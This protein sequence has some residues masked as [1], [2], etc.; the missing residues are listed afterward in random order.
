MAVAGAD[1]IRA[2][3][4]TTDHD[5]M[6][7]GGN[8]LALHL[9]SRDEL[10]LRGQKVHRK[11]HTVQL[12]TRHRQITRLLGATGQNHRIKIGHQLLRF[13]RVAWPSS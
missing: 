3:I 10:V 1:A 5:H 2:C 4:A 11:V 6:F 7:A 9:V 8:N 12:T 13:N